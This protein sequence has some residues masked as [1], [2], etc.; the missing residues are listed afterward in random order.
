[1][2]EVQPGTTHGFRNPLDSETRFVTSAD[3]GADLDTFL[4][5]IYQM[6]NDSVVGV[7]GPLRS[8]MLFGSIMAHTDMVL[9][10]IPRWLQRHCWS[11]TL[12]IAKM[13]GVDATHAFA[14]ARRGLSE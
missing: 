6:S 11:L 7:N 13:V 4:R 3:P 12:R 14:I 5:T 2:L 8:A 9:A 1:M 10:G